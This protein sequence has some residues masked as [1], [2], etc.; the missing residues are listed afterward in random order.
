[1]TTRVLTSRRH[2]LSASALTS[3]SASTPAYYGVGYYAVG[4]KPRSW[5][6]SSSSIS[7]LRHGN[8]RLSS[9]L[10]YPGLKT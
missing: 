1:M 10:Y 5:T 3:W 8:W 6:A 4:P 9:W 2:P 7:S